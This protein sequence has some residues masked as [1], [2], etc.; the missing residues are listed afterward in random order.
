M[1]FEEMFLKII[2]EKQFI[3]LSSKSFYTRNFPPIQPLVFKNHLNR[4]Q[5]SFILVA[6]LG[7][8]VSGLKNC[9]FLK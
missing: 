3:Q 5:K 1:V 6:I 7:L 4:K 2:L 9:I 8:F